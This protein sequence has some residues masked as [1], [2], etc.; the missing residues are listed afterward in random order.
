M[1]HFDTIVYHTSAARN[2]LTAVAIAAGE[3]AYP[4]NGVAGTGTLVYVKEDGW[5]F[6]VGT[7]TAAAANVAASRFHS[8]TDP[9]W[10]YWTQSPVTAQN[11]TG[12]GF[13]ARMMNC[14]YGV[15]K[16]EQVTAEV[17][18]GNNAQVDSVG[19]CIAKGSKPPYYSDIPPANLPPGVMLVYATTAH[20]NVANTWTEGPLT[21]TNYNLDRNKKYRIWGA[22]VDG[23]TLYWARFAALDGEYRGH[24]PGL[25]GAD[26]AAGAIR[27]FV[28]SDDFPTFSGLNGMNVQLLS[29]GADTASN[30][31]IAIEEIA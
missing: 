29:S 22:A 23:A 10:L 3:T 13:R 20:T 5:V 14:A 19:V 25:P 15:R 1:A 16:G 8:T 17:N 28:W 26:T 11:A 21:F 7:E 30:W 9:D 6:A 24:Y 12:S 31:L 4:A 27:P 18:N 2:G